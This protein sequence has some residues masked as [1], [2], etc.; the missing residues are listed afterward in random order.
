MAVD[1]ESILA[2]CVQAA[3]TFPVDVATTAARTSRSSRSSNRYY[4]DD[5]LTSFPAPALGGAYAGVDGHGVS[6]RRVD[7]EF[8][9]AGQEGTTRQNLRTNPVEAPRS[10]RRSSGDSR[11]RRPHP[12]ARCR[13]LHRQ[14]RSLVEELLRTLED[15]RVNEA[16]D[17]AVDGL[18]V[19]NLENVQGDERDTIL[20]STAFSKNS[21][22]ILPLNFGPLT[23]PGG[24]RRLNVAVTRARRQVV[25]FSSFDPQDLRAD[26]TTSLGIKHLRAYLELAQRGAEQPSAH[27]TTLC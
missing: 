5:Q 25:M 19:K 9:R 4:Y 23:S 16:L 13:D 12:I 7:G 20:F 24:E 17:S 1:E 26:E 11:R 18:F 15:P 8:M 3:S 22:G 14:Q 10:S 6:L 2:Q 21:R 27:G